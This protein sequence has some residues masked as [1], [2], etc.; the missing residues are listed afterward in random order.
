[1]DQRGALIADSLRFLLDQGRLPLAQV[2]SG[3]PLPPQADNEESLIY[4]RD[5]GYARSRPRRRG[6]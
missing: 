1:V 4:T 6:A 5:T 2:F 3:V